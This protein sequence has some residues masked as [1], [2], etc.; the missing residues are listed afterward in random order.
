MNDYTDFLKFP[1]EAAHKEHARQRIR[2]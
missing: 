1:R 2:H